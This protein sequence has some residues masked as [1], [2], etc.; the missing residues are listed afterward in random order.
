MHTPE[1]AERFERAKPAGV[2]NALKHRLAKQILRRF[3]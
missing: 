1:G 3:A 2:E